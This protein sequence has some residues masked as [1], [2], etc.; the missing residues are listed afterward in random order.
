MGKFSEVVSKVV[1]NQMNHLN[2]IMLCE[3][4]STAPLQILPIHSQTHIDGTTEKRPL[5]QNPINLDNKIYNVGDIVV[6]AFLQEVTEGGATRKF[7]LSDAVILGQA[8]KAGQYSGNCQFAKYAKGA[9]TS[10][11]AEQKGQGIQMKEIPELIGSDGTNES[12]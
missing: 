1:L 11:V 12:W 5:I 3:I 4:I 7:D 6:V 9:E 8:G 10:K 2:T